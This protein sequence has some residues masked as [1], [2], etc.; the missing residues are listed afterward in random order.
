MWSFANT[1]VRTVY[2][3]PKLAR[4]LSMTRKFGLPE[5][6][7]FAERTYCTASPVMTHCSRL[8][9]CE[10]FSSDWSDMREGRTRCRRC[11]LSSPCAF[12]LRSGQ[13]KGGLPLC[14]HWDHASSYLARLS[15]PSS[16]HAVSAFEL[17]G[18]IFSS[19]H[20]VA[21][22]QPWLVRASTVILVTWQ[23]NSGVR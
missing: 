14:C 12:E 15:Q 10:S 11:C 9:V 20:E 1:S 22:P 2:L 21:L 17:W 19:C 8:F 23:Y 6:P 16:M 18:S 3:P 13:T 4:S 7:A 5:A